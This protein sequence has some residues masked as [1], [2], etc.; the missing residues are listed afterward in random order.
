M[1]C[2]LTV[3][4]QG[5]VNSHELSYYRL[6]GL[7][8]CRGRKL[9]SLY[10]VRFT[11]WGPVNET[12]KRQIKKRKAA[13]AGIAQWIECGPANPRVAGSIPTQGTCLVCRSGL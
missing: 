11:V 6:K 1:E 13:L 7:G 4:S 2:T 9:F 5:Y 3:I 10:H 8:L 12:D